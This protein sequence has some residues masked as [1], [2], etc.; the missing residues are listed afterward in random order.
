MDSL[1]EKVYNNYY[2]D[3]HNN[4]VNYIDGD[5]DYDDDDDYCT[6][7]SRIPTTTENEFDNEFDNNDADVRIIS[8]C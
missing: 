4:D 3:D 5:D 2:F 1:I 6:F 8:C 7:I